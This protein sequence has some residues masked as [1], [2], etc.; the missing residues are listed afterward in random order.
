MEI[1][2]ARPLEPSEA[3]IDEINKCSIFV[4]IYAHRYGF[5]PNGASA[6]ITEMEFDR[7]RNQ[8]RQIAAIVF[9]LSS[10]AAPLMVRFTI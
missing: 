8:S 9:W 4:G 1:F 10:A 7:A 5:I 3:C 6:S 2:G